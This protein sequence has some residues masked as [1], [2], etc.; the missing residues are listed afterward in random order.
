VTNRT[1]VSILITLFFFT[2]IT[3]GGYDLSVSTG[4]ENLTAANPIVQSLET[5]TGSALADASNSNSSPILLSQ[6]EGGKLYKIEKLLIVQLSGSYR[7]M[8]RQEGYLLKEELHEFY[9]ES[10]VNYFIGEKNL[11]YERM[12]AESMNEF[13]LYPKRFRDII[14]GMVETSGISL[15]NLTILCR[16]PYIAPSCSAIFAWGNYSRDSSMVVGRN[17]DFY[18]DANDFL[19]YTIGVVYNP[20]DGSH[21]LATVCRPAQLQ[22]HTGMNDQ[23]LF[24]EAN[25]GSSSGGSI[26]Y[27]DRFTYIGS[28]L[29]DCSNL[30]QLDVA[31]FSSRINWATILNAADANTSISYEW[32]TFDLKRRGPDRDGL[33]TSTNHFVNPDWGIA[34]PLGDP[35]HTMVRRSNLLSLGEKYKGRFNPEIMMLVLD[36]TLEN[37]GASGTYTRLQVVAAPS[38]KEMWIKVPKYQNWTRV[39]L[40]GLFLS[41]D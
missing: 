38:T 37:G 36:T 29:F 33:L 17:I 5:E 28:F 10:V 18:S 31:V 22:I 19:N 14:S 26:I 24:L 21:S 32:A 41:P 9:N 40:K 39:D 1:S 27:P 34:L 12:R 7:E 11:S 3:L 6:F 20:T 13:G 8:G 25:D 35:D 4:T 30:R 15:A 23:G 16:V 2:G